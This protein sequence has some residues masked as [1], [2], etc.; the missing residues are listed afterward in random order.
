MST[1]PSIE[2]GTT[3]SQT[4]G[5]RPTCFPTVTEAFCAKAGKAGRQ[6]RRLRLHRLLVKLIRIQFFSPGSGTRSAGRTRSIGSSLREYCES[7]NPHTNSPTGRG[8]HL[9]QGWRDLRSLPLANL[10]SRLRRERL[11]LITQPQ[12]LPTQ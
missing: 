4:L 1:V 5:I 6:I 7:R 12:I 3:A 10:T 8:E 11:N 9:I 2:A